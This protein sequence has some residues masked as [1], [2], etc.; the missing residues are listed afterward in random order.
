MIPEK[1]SLSYAVGCNDFALAIE[2]V[3]LVETDLHAV[4]IIIATIAIELE[5][6][7]FFYHFA[8]EVTVLFKTDHLANFFEQLVFLKS[9]D[10]MI[11]PQLPVVIDLKN[12]LLNQILQIQWLPLSQ[13]I[14]QKF[15]FS[16]IFQK[17]NW[18]FL[19]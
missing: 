2:L 15:K 7:V 14:L 17:V 19:Q 18:I 10:L 1:T 16:S 13:L 3:L 6:V 9:Q 8:F 12:L 11:T 5:L 4:L